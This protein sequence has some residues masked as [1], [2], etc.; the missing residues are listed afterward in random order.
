MILSVDIKLY[1]KVLY[2]PFKLLVKLKSYRHSN[3]KFRLKYWE[4]NK[5]NNV[6][7]CLES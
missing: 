4:T 2:E 1:M 5:A 7:K 3:T 6:G